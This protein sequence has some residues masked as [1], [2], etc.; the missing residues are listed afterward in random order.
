V[1]YAKDGRV[2]SLMRNKFLVVLAATAVL[3][4]CREGSTAPRLGLVINTDKPS[5]SFATDSVAYVTLTNT[6][7]QTIHLPMSTYVV[8]ER[9]VDG[10]WR[11]A[12]DWFIVDGVGKSIPIPSGIHYRDD[13]PIRFYLRGQ[14]GTYRFRYLVYA[15]ADLSSLLH[16]S[17]RVSPPF[18]VSD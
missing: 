1:T 11:D 14:S 12:A 10:A 8:Y 13:L 18:T 3:S 5:Y 17:D 6:S 7:N 16:I 4:N 15:D 9:L 2:G